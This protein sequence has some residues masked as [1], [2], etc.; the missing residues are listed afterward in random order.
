MIYVTTAANDKDLLKLG[1]LVPIR[2]GD[3][4]FQG[5]AD[6]KNVKV[7]VE[8]KKMRDLVN[9][10][11]DGR[12]LQQVR[13]AYEAGFDYYT[14]V[15]EA[16]WRE[17][18]DGDTEYRSGKKWIRTGMPW[19]RI[20]AYLTELHYLMG[21][22]VVYSNNRKETIQSIKALY[23]FFQTEEHD[24]LKRFYV[25][26]V[27]GMLLQQ[28]SLVRRVAKELPGIGWERSLA[29]EAKWDSVRDM[30]NAPVEEWLKLDGIGQGIASRVQEELG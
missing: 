1:P 19:S 13:Q 12:H 20:Q 17:T 4:V 2:H 25:A 5:K 22:R 23:K 18:K 9:C 29:V 11:N 7:C 24:S 21:V 30:V 10:I 27:D 15:L 16:L 3:V 28:P 26:P 14:L 6:G 8:R